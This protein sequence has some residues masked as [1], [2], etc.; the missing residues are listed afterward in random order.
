MLSREEGWL[1]I[2]T[3]L[4]F[5]Q[6]KTVHITDINVYELPLIISL[7]FISR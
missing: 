4:K 6:A 3:E 5:S 1:E 2:F 7:L